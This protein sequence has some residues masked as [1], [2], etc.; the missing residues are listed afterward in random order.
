VPLIVNDDVTLAVTIGADGVHLGKADSDLIE[1]RARLGRAA[2][3]GISCYD[4]FGRALAAQ[5]QGAD[6]IAF[7]SVFPSPTKPNA[8]RAP[9]ALFTRARERLDVPIAAIGGLTPGNAGEAI[10]AGA[11]MI[12]VISGVFGASDPKAA[13][14]CYA[15]LF[16]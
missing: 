13:A 5:R 1:A 6:Y 9:L 3:I 7:G 15:R 8:V 2:I 16:D 10:A 4:S 12:A 11:S 14:R